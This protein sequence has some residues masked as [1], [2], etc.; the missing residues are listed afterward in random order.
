VK[1]IAPAELEDN[2]PDERKM[3]QQYEDRVW[4]GMRAPCV[5]GIFTAART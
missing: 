4:T 3:Q 2:Q 5:G 1:R